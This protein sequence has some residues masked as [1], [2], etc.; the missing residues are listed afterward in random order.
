[1]GLDIYT[2]TLT[3]YYTQ[4]WKT[5]TQ[6]FAE[7]HGI[8]FQTVRFQPEQENGQSIEEIKG[9]VTEW[10]DNIISGLK[11]DPA[12]LW[13]EDYDTTP[14]YTNKPDWDALHALMLYAAAKFSSQEV[15]ATIEKNFDVSRHSIVEEFLKS[16]EFNLTFFNENGWWLP[17]EDRFIFRYTLPNSQENTLA[18]SALLLAEL[19]SL[20]ALEWKADS[21]TIIS[22]STT[23]G[24]PVE[25][26]FSKEDGFKELA[27]HE[28]FETESLAK[29]AFSILW[30]AAEF[31][32]EHGAVMLY[33]Y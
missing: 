18:T 14:Y 24:Y 29:F 12:P 19:S 17:I 31:S 4:N 28:T 10:R 2:G 30:Q 22:W 16:T 5:A 33:D 3:R 20:N 1:M 25:G 32:L 11:L 27:S 9:I 13:N 8:Q 26:V 15:P 23:E 6:Q 21:M 7:A